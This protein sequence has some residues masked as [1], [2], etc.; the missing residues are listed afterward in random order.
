MFKMRK[1]KGGILDFLS[2]LLPAVVVFLSIPLALFLPNQSEFGFSPVVILPYLILFGLYIFF[3]FLILYLSG[4]FLRNKIV[5]ILFYSGIF[6]FLSDILSPVQLGE[7]TGNH[8]PNIDEPITLTAIELILAAVLILVAFRLPWKHVRQFGPMFVVLLLV[9]EIFSF[10]KDFTSTHP[11]QADPPPILADQGNIYHFIFDGF[12]SPLFLWATDKI[13][14]IKKFNEFVFFPNNRS[15]YFTTRTSLPSFM[16]GTFYEGKESLIKWRSRQKYSGIFRH[17]Y[18]AGYEIS[19]YSPFPNWIHERA[20]RI[21]LNKFEMMSWLFQF[22]DLWLLRVAPNFLQQEIY[23]D[24][25]GIFS[26]SFLRKEMAGFHPRTMSGVSLMHQLIEDEKERPNQGQYI[27]A[28]IMVPHPPNVLDE[29]CV[30][31]EKSNHIP[32]VLCAVRLMGDFISK[33]KEYEK[34]NNSI[35][36]FQSD[37]A[38]FSFHDY[39]KISID[40]QRMLEKNWGKDSGYLIASRTKAL[41]LIKPPFRLK[42][43]PFFFISDRQTQLVDLPSTIYDIAGLRVKTKEGMSVFSRNFPSSREIHIFPGFHDEYSKGKVS[44]F[45]KEIKDGKMN[46]LS[47]TKGKGW[48]VYPM[49]QAQ[50]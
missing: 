42:K 35:I 20:S 32:Q 38:V 15:N 44:L 40:D 37:H 41:L 43:E 3:L 13:K 14:N 17:F 19:M 36:I 18:D 22:A 23:S 34:F 7:L 27:F 26:K 12:P 9:F 5:P 8:N 24:D 45:A 16:T 21:Y 49:F 30:Y 31:T 10:L 39:D 50:Q 29:N 6:L 25:Q 4:L 46:H 47:F 48:K 28:H 33:L 1:K 2:A 11:Q